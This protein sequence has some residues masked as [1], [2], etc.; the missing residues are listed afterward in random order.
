MVLAEMD[1]MGGLCRPRGPRCRRAQSARS[2]LRAPIAQEG[3]VPTEGHVCCTKTR[4]V[5]SKVVGRDGT[6]LIE[7]ARLNEAVGRSRVK[8]SIQIEADGGGANK[9]QQASA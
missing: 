8:T 1:R 4:V 7:T 6:P 3:V 9:D 5:V 2:W